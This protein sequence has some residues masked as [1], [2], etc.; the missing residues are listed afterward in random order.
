MNRE[1]NVKE[2]HNYAVIKVSGQKYVTIYDKD[3]TTPLL[4]DKSQTDEVKAVL[5]PGNYVIESDGKI[6]S[7]TSSLEKGEQPE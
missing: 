4:S 6:E 3:R 1:F 2:G 5:K 7:V